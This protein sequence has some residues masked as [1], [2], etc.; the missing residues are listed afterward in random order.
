[1]YCD[2]NVGMNG[3]CWSFWEIF[4]NDLSRFASNMATVQENSSAL[5]RLQRW[6]QKSEE[7]EAVS[8]F[9]EASFWEIKQQILLL[10]NILISDLFWLFEIL[11]RR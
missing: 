8:N 5:L 7:Y 4:E 9:V 3:R 2:I 10:Q 11:N 1:M 6:N